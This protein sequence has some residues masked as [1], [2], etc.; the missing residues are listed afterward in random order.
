[1]KGDRLGTL[2]IGASLVVIALVIFLTVF[3]A[4]QEKIEQIRVQGVGLVRTFSMLPL[5]LLSPH[6]QA[7]GALQSLLAF[8]QPDAFAYGLVTSVD[9]KVLTQVAAPGLIPSAAPLPTGLESLYGERELVASGN[10]RKLLEFY[11]PVID[12]ETV[13]AFVRLGYYTPPLV[14]GA[15]D[16]SF[17]ALMAL[18]VFLLVP[19]VYFLFRRE[20]RPLKEIQTAIQANILASAL[21]VS[22]INPAIDVS[23]LAEK[24]TSFV[25]ETRIRISQLQ[26]EQISMLASNRLLEYQRNKIEHVLHSMPD[27]VMLLDPSGKIAFASEKIKPLLGIAAEVELSKV[28]DTWCQDEALRQMLLRYRSVGSHASRTE[29]INLQ[30]VAAPGNHVRILAQALVSP[31]ENAVFG[32]LVVFHDATLEHQGKQA[33]DEFVGHVSHELKSPLNVLSLYA[34]LLQGD[35][36]NDEALRIEAANTIYHEVD[37]MASLV[38]NLLNI[39][40]LE[41][42]GVQATCSRVK[43]DELLRDIFSGHQARAKSSDITLNL[44]VPNEISALLIDKD[45]IRI[46]VNN[47]VTN[48]I[49]YSDAGGRIT[50]SATETDANVVISVRDNGVGI[51]PEDRSRIFEKFYRVDAQSSQRSG[52]GLGLYLTQQIVQLHHGKLGLESQLGQGS[53]FSIHLKKA[54]LFTSDMVLL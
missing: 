52:H 29:T 49:K 24:V 15:K 37:R 32:T 12:S 7:G 34:E 13:V 43:T 20:L 9:G 41:T 33:G 10:G 3:K 22:F 46:A 17:L 11:G 2:I 26:S 4:R 23:T 30:P 19:A 5:P 48:A 44:E 27:G 6:N 18:L 53:T 36:L 50:L 28:M 31:L 51:S 21:P 42:G 47:L 8:A 39:S 1:M 25:N 35:G 14:V 38:N 16:L 45:L 54:T 40:K